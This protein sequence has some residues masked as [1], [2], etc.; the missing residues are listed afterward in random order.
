MKYLDAQ[1]IGELLKQ[2]EGCDTKDLKRALRAIDRELAIKAKQSAR[3]R[4]MIADK[5]TEIYAG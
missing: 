1:L 3:Y 5:R 4:R 2:C